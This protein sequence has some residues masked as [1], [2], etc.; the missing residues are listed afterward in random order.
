VLGLA[1]T[2]TAWATTESPGCIGFIGVHLL[3]GFQRLKL[4]IFY[5]RHRGGALDRAQLR[6][7][8]SNYQFWSILFASAI[9]LQNLVVAATSPPG[10]GWTLATGVAV[11]FTV[12]FISRSSGRMFLFLAQS[13]AMCAP[14]MFAYAFLPGQN[15]LVYA[16]LFAVM[17]ATVSLLA[18]S[19]HDKTVE[20]YRAHA[21]TRLVANCD[22]LTGLLN[23]HAFSEALEQE[24]GRG[25]EGFG[26][27][28]ID[29]DRFKT[30]NDTLGHNAGDAVLVEIAV[31][32]RHILRED[33]IVARI[34]GD[35]FMILTRRAAGDRGCAENIAA[36]I[37]DAL[38]EPMVLDMAP[39]QAGASVG[40]ALFPEHGASAQDL[41]QKADLALYEAKKQGRGQARLFDAAM[42]AR[43]NEA[44]ILE[45]EIEAAIARDEF[46]PWHQPIVNILTGETLGFE[47]LARWPHPVRGLIPPS[48]FIPSAEQS[49][50]I[51]AIGRMILEKACADAATWPGG[52]EVSVNLSP[53]QFRQPQELVE[54]V[55]RALAK[56]G[57][58]PQRLNLEITETVMIDDADATRQAITEL[59]DL[60]VRMSL[61]DFGAGYSSLSYIQSYPFSKIKIDKCFIDRIGVSLASS[62]IVSAV[63]VLADQLDLD[64][65]A[66]GVETPEQVK[67]LRE[68]GVTMAQGFYFGRPARAPEFGTTARAAG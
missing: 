54:M 21:R 8:D 58:S 35:E 19:T 26:L 57:L 34:G 50:A 46:E 2:L 38:S 68:L 51:V 5:E 28:L 20:L 10:Q 47:A 30:I 9:G 64:L 42:Q 12:G 31:R 29:L 56:T 49:G 37:I 7:F 25:G 59:T 17:L 11:G 27:V 67:A 48:R 18:W 6:R 16:A 1:V 14:M 55:R 22:M 39:T 63:R 62:A 53:V 66:E 61:D 40:I 36:L 4:I 13:S 41:L 65:I 45:L 23:R 44:R 24:I 15:G 43:F 3:V 52:E 33:D 32:L 60:G